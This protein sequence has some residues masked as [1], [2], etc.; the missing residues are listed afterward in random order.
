MINTAFGSFTGV[1]PL[2]NRLTA[3]WQCESGAAMT[4]IALIWTVMIMVFSG[5]AIDVARA[6][7]LRVMIQ[8][9]T[10]RCA[11][12]AADIDQELPPRTVVLDCFEKAGLGDFISADDIIVEPEGADAVREGRRVTVNARG[13]L[14][15]STM[16]FSNIDF[17]GAPAAATAEELVKNI[18]IVM[19]LDVSGSMGRSNR[20]VRLKESA[21]D[22]IDKVVN[23]E[24]ARGEVSISIVPYAGQVNAS[25]ALL[26]HYNISGPIFGNC[27]NFA[28]FMFGET[29]L[30][31][32]TYIIPR[33]Y[34]FDPWSNRKEWR[35]TDSEGPYC[36]QQD[37]RAIFLPSKNAEALKAHIRGFNSDGNTSIDIG[38]KWGATLMDPTFREVMAGLIANGD[39][40]ADLADRPFDYFD[41]GPDGSDKYIIVMSDGKNTDQYIITEEYGEGDSP[42]FRDPSG[43]LS[44]HHPGE[45]ESGGRD[46]Y[47]FDN[48]RWRTTPYGG[49]DAIDTDRLSWAELWAT[50]SIKW[51]LDELYQDPLDLSNA[52]K[53]DLRWRNITAGDPDDTGIMDRI[54]P[55]VKD[56]RTS[57]ICTAVKTQGVKV[58]AI[59]FEAPPEGVAALRDCASDAKSEHFFDVNG[60][61]IE[62]AFDSI[63]RA[64]TKLRLT[65]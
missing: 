40:S 10:D 54:R 51:V 37:G 22:F 16:S 26:S 42:V 23:N 35:V 25:A 59:A 43:R 20:M 62:T 57:E 28:S 38:M 5:I 32:S 55:N 13:V 63:A 18:E 14:K 21:Q 34:V 31:P 46:Y 44:I 53:E 2:K 58:F 47:Q 48:N 61:G 30:D 19:V 52:E 39:V 12:A 1:L 4:F 60:P 11:L 7:H 24:D 49:S 65:Q 56:Q 50:Y 36:P 8:N 29:P 45:G 15:T 64:I 17:L 41:N 33:A 6:E 27:V 9:A 3:F